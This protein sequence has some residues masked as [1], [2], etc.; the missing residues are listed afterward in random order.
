MGGGRR[1]SAPGPRF[2]TTCHGGVNVARLFRLIGMIRL[3]VGDAGGFRMC[4]DFGVCQGRDKGAA[5]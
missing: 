1:T 2:G 5:K 3:I 4:F